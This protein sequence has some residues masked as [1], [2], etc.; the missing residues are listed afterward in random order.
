MNSATTERIFA[1]IIL[2]I[3]CCLLFYFI[4]PQK[5]ELHSAIKTGLSI[6]F[7]DYTLEIIADK[8]GFWHYNGKFLF[9]GLSV[10]MFLDISLVATNI[11]IGFIYFKRKGHI[12]KKL[13]I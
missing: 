11:C 5:K 1:P 10:D 12:L 6:A 9:L 13:F 2:I 3:F 4:K 7:L 8:V